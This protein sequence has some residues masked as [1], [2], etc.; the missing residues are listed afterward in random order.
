MRRR[1]KLCTLTTKWSEED[2]N[3]I[4]NSAALSGAAID[5]LVETK[6]VNLFNLWNLYY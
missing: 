6:G 3:D 4:Y 1:R 2:F 5:R